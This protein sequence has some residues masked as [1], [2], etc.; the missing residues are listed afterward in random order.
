MAGSRPSAQDNPPTTAGK[1]SH[2]PRIKFEPIRPQR[3]RER[4]KNV[5]SDVFNGYK[6]LYIA[7]SAHGS[8]CTDPNCDNTPS[9]IV[10]I[11]FNMPH[12]TFIPTIV[13][14]D[15]P[16]EAPGGPNRPQRLYVTAK[17]GSKLAPVE[18]E[19]SR[20]SSKT[21]SQ[22]PQ[23]CWDASGTSLGS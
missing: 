21:T 1:V 9:H 3:S 16:L 7:N 10:L 5:P 13:Y 17:H 18:P 4:S 20:R 8:A 14:L 6:R 12:A 19:S 15:L 11:H 23:R 2:P 22:H